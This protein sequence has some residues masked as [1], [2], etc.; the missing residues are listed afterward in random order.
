MFETGKISGDE[1]DVKGRKWSQGEEEDE[2]AEGKQDPD[3]RFDFD[4]LFVLRCHTI[5]V[6]Q[7]LVT[8]L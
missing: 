8:K 5:N 6:Q 7:M 2:T 4:L 3:D 1:V